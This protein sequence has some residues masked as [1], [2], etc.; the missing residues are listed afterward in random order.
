MFCIFALF[1]FF[2]IWAGGRLTWGVSVH[3]IKYHPAIRRAVSVHDASFGPSC[4]VALMPWIASCTPCQ[5]C[6][7]KKR[8]SSVARSKFCTIYV[9]VALWWQ[10]CWDLQNLSNSRWLWKSICIYGFGMYEVSSA[11]CDLSWVTLSCW[12]GIIKQAGG[13]QLCSIFLS[14]Y[15][16]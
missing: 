3:F 12:C 1:F 6:L 13:S 15:Q 4:P 11:K 10:F 2:R 8:W 16:T 9:S 14:S 7:Q 5:K